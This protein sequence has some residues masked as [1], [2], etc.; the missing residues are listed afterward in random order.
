MELVHQAGLDGLRGELRTAHAEIAGGSRLQVPDRIRVE[1]SLEPRPR[2]G[3]RLQGLRVHDLLGGLPDLRVVPEDGL[4]AG[5]GV[6][7]LP[8]DQHLVHATPQEVRADR[9]LEVVDERVHFLVRRR[10]IELAVLVRDVAVQ[11]RD[12]GVDQLRHSA[13]SSPLTRNAQR[14]RHAAELDGEATHHSEPSELGGP[15]R[16]ARPRSSLS[17]ARAVG[18]GRRYGC[19]SSRR[20]SSRCRPHRGSG[21][22]HRCGKLRSRRP[23]GRSW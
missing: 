13:S 23:P 10:P 11:R 12:R 20:A 5:E 2:A 9:P 22:R 16:S 17:R 14:L 8:D 15:R 18:N 4:L 3:H 7:V 1:V 6:R 19:R 21:S